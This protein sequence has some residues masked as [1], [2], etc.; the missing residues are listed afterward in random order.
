MR[1]FTIVTD[2]GAD[3]SPETLAEWGVPCGYLTCRFEGEDK[4]FTRKDTALKDFFNRMRSGDVAKTAAVNVFAFRTIFEEELKKGNDVLY[5]GLS[6]GISTTSNSGIIAAQELAP[7]WPD[8]KII[9]IDTLSASAGLALMVWMAKQKKD[10]GCSI[11]E[12]ADYIRSLIP[13]NAHWFTV[14]DLIYLKRGGRIS[15]ASY[16]AASLLDIR[17]V[18]HVDDEGKLISMSK[19][20]SRKKS[21]KAMADKLIETAKD[22]KHCVYFISNADCPEDAALLEQMI[23]EGTGCKA[24]LI[25]EIGPVIG[26]HAGP[27]T[28]ALFFLAEHR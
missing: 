2:S 28:M 27:G 7:E 13:Y 11:E 9:A 22:P 17:P 5:L 15:A 23:Y 18:L 25:T 8:R 14:D 4:E 1:N 19:V 21:L 16:F 26:A 12:T 6:S 10:E 20:R 24:T 3:L